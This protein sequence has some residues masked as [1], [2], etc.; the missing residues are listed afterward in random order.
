MYMETR[1][2]WGI[3]FYILCLWSQCKSVLSLIFIIKKNINCRINVEN[4]IRYMLFIQKHIFKWASCYYNLGCFFFYQ[5]HSKT[6]SSVFSCSGA[7][8][9][10]C[11]HSKALHNHPPYLMG[12]FL[13]L[14]PPTCALVMVSL[15]PIQ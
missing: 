11:Q 4:I 6:L 13:D 8:C 3:K 7:L 12:F 9:L 2:I 5:L 1:K 10:S 15:L 14:L